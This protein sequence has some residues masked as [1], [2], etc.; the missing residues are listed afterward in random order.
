MTDFTPL[1]RDAFQDDSLPEAHRDR[2]WNTMQHRHARQARVRFL[3]RAG[4][5]LLAAAILAAWAFL[6]MA[7]VPPSHIAMHADS[8]STD[9]HMERSMIQ[10]KADIMSLLPHRSQLQM[11]V[12]RLENRQLELAQMLNGARPGRERNVLEAQAQSVE[13]QL[14]GAKTALSVVDAQL[15]GH[16]GI[17]MNPVPPMIAE[18]AQPPQVITVS[19]GGLSDEMI[20]SSGGVGLLLVLAMLGMVF[21]MRRIARMTRDAL[22]AVERQ[23]S[24]QHATLASGIDAIAVEVERLGEGQRFMSKVLSGAEVKAP[25][26]RT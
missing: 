8:M 7:P 26:S 6:R 19:G 21:Y 5:V 10:D 13:E 17:P 15:A 23:V 22:V 11:E 16:A 9:S 25:V 20:W 14:A 3:V 18:I 1:V 2:L 12:G 24:S 4:L